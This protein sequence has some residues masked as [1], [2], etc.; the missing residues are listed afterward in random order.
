[1]TVAARAG[2]HVNTRR[3]LGNVDDVL[4]ILPIAKS[5]VYDLARE[6]RLPGVVKVG[7][8]LLFD[9]Q[10]LDLWIERGG[11]TAT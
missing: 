9:L 3:R 7:R 11:G 6:G 2:G 4:D 10:V 8:R 1:M 5:S